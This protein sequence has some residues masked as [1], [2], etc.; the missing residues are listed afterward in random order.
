MDFNL[1]EIYLR[2]NPIDFFLFDCGSNGCCYYNF[3]QVKGNLS[4]VF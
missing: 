1:C 4:I 3:Y 2:L